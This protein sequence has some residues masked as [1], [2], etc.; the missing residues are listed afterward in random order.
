MAYEYT[1]ESKIKQWLV[2]IV[3]FGDSP[4]SIYIFVTDSTNKSWFIACHPR[5]LDWELFPAGS[6]HQ[7]FHIDLSAHSQWLMFLSG[8]VFDTN[9]Q[10]VLLFH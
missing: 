6:G 4:N 8:T 9:T 5:S 2:C 1:S 7:P 3:C 10:T